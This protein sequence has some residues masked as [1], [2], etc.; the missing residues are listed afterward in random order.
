MKTKSLLLK[1]SPSISTVSAQCFVPQKCKCIMTIAHG[2]GAG[3]NH[4]F[5]IE[6]AGSLS[7]VGIATMRFNFP[8]MENKKGR[9]DIPSVAHQTIEAAI[10]KAQKLFPKLPLFVAGK[11]FGGRMT[12]QYL[13]INHNNDIKGV[14]FYGFP[15]HAPGNPSIERAAHLKDVKTPMLF[16]QGTRDEFATGKLIDKVCSSLPLA[17]LVKIEGANHAFKAGKENVIKILTIETN[18]WIESTVSK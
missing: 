13:A 12:S 16:L 4:P 17:K 8:F 15:L 11:S 9:P 6:L 14:I 1:V 18:N 2:A 3:M 7:E 5:M 10:L